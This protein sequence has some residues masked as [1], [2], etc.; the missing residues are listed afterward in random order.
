M[1]SPG[2]RVIKQRFIFDAVLFQLKEKQAASIK[3]F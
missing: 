2:G 1:N 3:L